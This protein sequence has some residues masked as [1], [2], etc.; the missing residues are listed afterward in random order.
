MDG[1]PATLNPISTAPYNVELLLFDVQPDGRIIHIEIGRG[2]QYVGDRISWIS[3]WSHEWG[4]AGAGECHYTP[5]HWLAVP[6][7]P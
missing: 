2:R 4:Y 3:L 5:T 6:R 1:M 7:L